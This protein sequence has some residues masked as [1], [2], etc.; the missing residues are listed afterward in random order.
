MFKQASSHLKLLKFL[1]NIHFLIEISKNVFKII[2][3]VFNNWKKNDSF[4]HSQVS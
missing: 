2:Q 1:H 3:S 4:I